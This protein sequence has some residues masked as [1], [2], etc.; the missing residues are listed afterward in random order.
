MTKTM[1]RFRHLLLA[2]GCAL[3]VFAHAADVPAPLI[4]ASPNSAELLLKTLEDRL[5]GN[6]FDPVSMN[7]LAVIR[8]KENNPY[9]AAELLARAH[10]LDPDNTVITANNTN[11]GKW[12]EARAKAQVKADGKPAEPLDDPSQPFPPEP[13]PLWPSR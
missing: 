1:I 11:L 3:P 2:A 12:I 4:G 8:L 7:N 5:G 13:P 9:A 10:Q 6:P